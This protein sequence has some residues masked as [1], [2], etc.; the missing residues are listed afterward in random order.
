MRRRLF[1]ALVP[2]LLFATALA[3]A[4]GRLDEVLATDRAF[5]ARASE[6]GAQAAF[7]EFLAPDGVLF[8]PTAVAGLE[9]LRSHDEATGQL[10]WSPVAGRVSCDGGLAVTLGPWTYRQDTVTA[11]GYYLTVWRRDDEGRWVVALDHGIDVP[12]AGMADPVPFADGPLPCAPPDPDARGLGR[13]NQRYDSLLA[14][15]GPDAAL[16]QRVSASA[17]VMRDGHAPAPAGTGWPLDTRA[18]GE[19]L[20]PVT[21]G[22]GGAAGSDLGYAWGEF[23]TAGPRGAD[24][25]PVRAVFARVWVR[26]G[27]E[28]RLLAD[29]VTGVA[30][31]P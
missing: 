23:A 18:F 19:R 21:R 29:L 20:V 3:Q 17:L 11:T 24:R 14:S 10:A 13:A 16:R 28:W 4:D 26:E 5:A 8:R 2:S 15:Q 7:Q 25:G 30:A 6:V 12:A 27:R 31:T 9:W 22:V 1:A